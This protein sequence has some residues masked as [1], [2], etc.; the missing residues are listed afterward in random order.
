MSKSDLSRLED[1]VQV[2]ELGRPWQAALLVGRLRESGIDA[3]IV[4]QTFRQEMLPD[5]R[6]FAIVRVFVPIV[7]AEQ[8]KHLISSQDFALPEDVDVVPTDADEEDER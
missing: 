2:A 6:A 7:Q 1:W 8:A 5:V 4:D 3:Q